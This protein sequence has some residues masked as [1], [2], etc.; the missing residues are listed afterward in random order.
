MSGGTTKVP[1]TGPRAYLGSGSGAG[2]S[3]GQTQRA[4]G[5]VSSVVAG[6]SLSQ[7]NS[8]SSPVVGQGFTIPI[9]TGPRSMQGAGIGVRNLEGSI[10]APSL[11]GSGGLH[12]TPS[13][14]LGKQGGPSKQVNIGSLNSNVGAAAIGEGS[15]SLSVSSS[16]NGLHTKALPTGPASGTWTILPPNS[17]ASP[18]TATTNGMRL[19]TEPKV[20]QGLPKGP[21]LALHPTRSKVSIP[22]PK[23]QPS[24]STTI[25]S[26][27]A[28][29]SLL[30][31]SST[32]SASTSKSISSPSKSHVSPPLPPHSNSPPPPPPPPSEPPQAPPEPPVSVSEPPPPPPPEQLLLPWPPPPRSPSIRD[33]KAIYD[34]ILEKAREKKRAASGAPPL[35]SSS[36]TKGKGK[37]VAYRYNG[38]EDVEQATEG[39]LV[40]ARKEMI[41]VDPRKASGSGISLDGRGVRTKD[42]VYQFSEWEVSAFASLFFQLHYRVI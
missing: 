10:N 3:G 37:E 8:L 35:P 17:S 16:L 33:Y 18:T 13:I 14:L 29:T 31:T 5:L 30:A 9:P 26:A 39:N 1:P 12:A 7:S 21:A 27:T 40:S 42:Y 41:L 22:T 28:S 24:T 32:P 19:P 25:P 11:V 15:G 2:T 4:N 36:S 38:G 6:P 20:W 34:P 23:T